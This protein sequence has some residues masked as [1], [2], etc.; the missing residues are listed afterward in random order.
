MIRKGENF[1]FYDKDIDIFPFFEGA[2]ILYYTD[3]SFGNFLM[4]SHDNIEL[5]LV[6]EG[7]ISVNA[8][9]KFYSVPRGGLALIPPQLLHHS[10]LGPDTKCYERLVLHV[11][12]EYLESIIRHSFVHGLSLDFTRQIQII[13]YS[14]DTL[15]LLRTLFERILH[16]KKQS[17]EYQQHM[18]PCLLIEL[19]TELDY[20]LKTQGS[21]VPP[22]TNLLVTAVIDYID[23]HFTEPGLT[24]EEIRKSVYVSQGYLSRLFKDYT[25]SSIYNYLTYKRLIHSKELLA[26]GETVL[27]ACVNCGF[28]D[29]TS[30]LKSF[31]KAFTMTPSQYRKEYRQIQ[32]STQKQPAI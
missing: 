25:G 10:V 30:F 27:D 13:P 5:I 17:Q 12:R 31:K 8:E 3:T 1:E 16:A 2:N 19:F 21:P 6:L 29:Y 32:S 14:P 18:I 9:G 24:V 4:H 15:W 28:T 11:F 23:E 26:A 22:K 20:L 7:D